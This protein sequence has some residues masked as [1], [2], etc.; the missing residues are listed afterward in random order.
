M[1]IK[2]IEWLKKLLDIE[3]ISRS[4]LPG[5]CDEEF[6]RL[7]SMGVIENKRKGAGYVL[8]LKDREHIE[9]LISLQEIPQE[10]MPSKVNAVVTH[11]NAHYGKTEGIILTMSAIEMGGVAYKD[12]YM[13]VARQVE[14]FGIA[15]VFADPSR[16][17]C[18]VEGDI[19][20]VENLDV[21]LKP[22]LYLSKSGFKGVLLYYA[23]N[24]SDD[25]LQWVDVS[26]MGDVVVFPDYDITGLKNYLRITEALHQSVSMYVPDNLEELLD[27]FGDVEMM[28]NMDSRKEII[29]TNNKQASQVYE[30]L[31]KKGKGLHQEALA[32]S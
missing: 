31:L 6:S 10:G 16:E 2:S 23:G 3:T 27:R 26:V 21:I 12:H 20:L 7:I 28:A 19:G 8:N 5:S 29:R 4:K 15:A 18:T 17:P 30:I 11:K 24:I 32:L 14:K 1:N 25:L 22:E 13:D 9:N